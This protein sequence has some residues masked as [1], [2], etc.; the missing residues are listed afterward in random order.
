M[1]DLPDI[2]LELRKQEKLG[3]LN[4]KSLGIYQN[5]HESEKISNENNNKT[6]LYHEKDFKNSTYN[7]SYNTDDIPNLIDNSISL[8]EISPEIIMFTD[9]KGNVLNVNSR[10]LDWLGYE[11]EDII[12]K[13]LLRLPFF[14]DKYKNNVFD[15]SMDVLF[16][17]KFLSYELD[18]ITKSGEKR[19][20][21]VHAVPIKN[22]N[23]KISGGLIMI[24]DVTESKTARDEINK[25]SQFQNNV[26]D[27][28]NVWLSVMDVSANVLVWNKAAEAITGYSREEVIG[29][30]KIWE[31]L[32]PDAGQ[33]QGD[34]TGKGVSLIEGA[35][36]AQNFETVIKRRDGN[37]RTISWNPHTLLD[38]TNNPIGS[39]A[40][41]RDIT[42]QKR[43]EEKIKKQNAQL[44]KLNRIKSDFL[45]VTSHELRTP[46]VAIKGY[47]QLL[48]DM[49]LGEV[50]EKQKKALDIVL[51]NTN[52]LN[53]LVQ[54]IL[55]ISRLESGTMK[56]IPEKTDTRQMVEEIVETMQSS[57]SMKE[58]KINA[59]IEGNIPDL[60]VD[61]ERIKQVIINLV[62]NAIKF[63]PH[64][65]DINMQARK[66]GVYVLFEVR[67]F[68]RGIPKN[69]KE[70]IFET[71]YQ[72]DCAKDSKLLGG[73]G[74]GLAI[75]RGIVIAHGGKIWVESKVGIESTFRFVLPI[76]PVKDV[77]GRFK[78]IDIFSHEE[79][80]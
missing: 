75:S 13:N 12:G 52:R 36:F 4:S 46:M 70:K 78:E 23:N 14:A 62:N 9:I 33:Y 44:K 67:D 57:A 69:K 58:I 21:S 77:E 17:E 41:G 65:S 25:L 3:G 11:R 66:E 22:V 27:N 1:R 28:A 47:V 6:I 48:L 30:D 10:I 56:F 54:D 73:A 59:D 51:R 72:V 63:S 79:Y 42:D 29:N 16:S 37:T 68:G 50:T 64:G 74:M 76:K 15:F 38:N 19:T 24:S 71:F 45:N 43:Y 2:V 55:D 80:T 20:G 61:S 39:I 5:L 40:L 49:S 18:F 7:E 34:V 32:S 53:N 60:T 31:W 26:I 8:F 35:V